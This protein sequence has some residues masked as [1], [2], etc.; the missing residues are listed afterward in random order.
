[1][2][3]ETELLEKAVQLE[4]LLNDEEV[5]EGFIEMS[6]PSGAGWVH[7]SDADDFMEAIIADSCGGGSCKSQKQL[8]KGDLAY[9]VD[10]LVN[11]LP[12]VSF[13]AQFYVELIV[14]GGLKAK[15]PSNQKKLDDWLSSRNVY[16]QTNANV[17]R[18]ALFAAVTYGYSGLRLIGHGLVYVQPDHFTIWNLPGTMQD[19][20][21]VYQPIPGI[22]TPFLYEITTKKT[23]IEEEKKP[24]GL[25]AD[26]T[27]G[28][29]IR[30]KGL[31]K[32]VDGSY[33]PQAYGAAAIAGSD[34]FVPTDLF[35]HL[36]HSDEGQYGVSPLTK[37]RLRTTLIVDYIKNVIDEVG[38]DGTDYMMYLKA[39]NNIGTSLAGLVANSAASAALSAATDAKNVKNAQ[40]KTME[41]ARALATKMKR[42]KKT[43]MNIINTNFI[44]RIERLAGTVEL[45][46]YLSILNDAK[47]VVADIY[48]I[49]AL[50]AGSSG[51]GWSTGM[52]SLIPFT[53]ERT[54][55]PFAQRYSEQLQSIVARAAGIKGKVGFKEINTTDDKE[56]AEIEKIAS[57][58][59]KNIEQANKAQAEAAKIKKET[60][61]LKSGQTN[62][63]TTTTKTTK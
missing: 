1:M 25:F 15:D 51:G 20:N 6:N 52:S 63:A 8:E 13:V 3:D 33:Y 35:C 22:V 17:I 60:R 26:T 36:R 47:G 32:A 31:K 45:N 24:G 2:N 43:R 16:N 61:L 42:S 30:E 19:K 59:K 34:V 40:Q 11:N 41:T 23:A 56:M 46:Q 14:H 44:D 5:V 27:A 38:N 7:T 58:T 28:Q 54:I 48:G 57:E 12:A 49:P 9:S 21:G 4:A 29:A 10:Y 50:L 39:R 53:L 18:E 37:D 55:K 62:T